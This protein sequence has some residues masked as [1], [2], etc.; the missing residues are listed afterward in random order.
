[1]ARVGRKVKDK[2]VMKLICSPSECAPPCAPKKESGLVPLSFRVCVASRYYAARAGY[3]VAAWGA[4][5]SS[6]PMGSTVR[7]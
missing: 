1:M 7:P 2:C 3:A 4:G 5:F 6:E